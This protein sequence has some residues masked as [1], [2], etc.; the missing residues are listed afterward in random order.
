LIQKA[1]VPR[2]PTCGGYLDRNL[3]IDDYFVQTLYMAQRKEYAD[4]VSNSITGKLVMLEPGDRARSRSYTVRHL[5]GCIG[6]SQMPHREFARL[7]TEGIRHISLCENKSLLVVEDELGQAVRRSG[8]SAIQYWR[9]GHLPAKVSDVETLAREIVQRGR[10]G[11]AWL[12]RFLRSANYPDLYALCEDLFPNYQTRHLPT[13][14]TPLIG[15]E[16]DVADTLSMLKDS[17]V[18]LLTLTGAPGVGKTRLALQVAAELRQHFE[19]GVAFVQLAPIRDPERLISVIAGALGLI[20]NDDQPLN[21]RLLTFLRDRNLLLVL[22]NFE[23]VITAALHVS[24]L[25]SAA[26]RLKVLITSRESLH[27][28]G[29]YEYLVIPLGLPKP[30][31]R[32]K[33]ETLLHVPAVQLFVERARAADPLFQLSLDNAEAIATICTRL[34]G[35]PLAIELAASRSKLLTPHKILEQLND[36]LTLLVAGSRDQTARQ[37]SLQVAIEW[38]Y[39]LLSDPEKELFRRL[40]VFQGGC[41]SDAIEAVCGQSALSAQP[42]TEGQLWLLLESLGNK[43]LIQSVPQQAADDKLRCSMLE[44]IHEYAYSC[45]QASGE[46]EEIHRRHRDWCLTLAERAEKNLRGPKQLSWLR[47]LEQEIHN[48]RA[49]LAWCL[50]HPADVEPGLRLAGALYWF[51]HL[52]SYFSEGCDWLDKLLALRIDLA[53]PLS[54]RRAQAKALCIASR[55]HG[56]EANYSKAAAL[57]EAGFALSR[58]IGELD[59]LVCALTTP[60]LISRRPSTDVQRVVTLTEAILPAC[61]AAGDPFSVAQLLDNVLGQVAFTRGDYAQAA[62]LH[63]E[64]LS[65]RRSVGDI[66]GIAWSLFLLGGIARARN[67][68]ARVQELYEESRMLWQQVGNRRMYA[69]VLNELGYLALKQSRYFQASALFEENLVTHEGFGDRYRAALAQCALATVACGQSDY[70]LV[71]TYLRR[72]ATTVQQ[73]KQPLLIAGYLGVAAELA[74]T[75]GAW[76]RVTRLLG[77]AQIVLEKTNT[78]WRISERM[79]YDEMLEASRAALGE[80]AFEQAW[81]EG[82]AMLLEAAI[83]YALDE[84]SDSIQS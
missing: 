14:S 50:A 45:L 64:A 68:E 78:R 27:I 48:L 66:D 42:A 11:R 22:D 2:C 73:L 53:V 36:Q 57:S 56:F 58:E 71:R 15:R 38:S 76:D 4:F 39:A 55:L 54:T 49:A 72:L 51:W 5:A 28:Y 61:R 6:K 52:H 83:A 74:Y 35:L 59:G 33:Y 12:E 84:R 63:E 75:A 37:Q 30:E 34:D 31:A 79:R 77:V 81:R 26:P 3:R 1:D 82:Q 24:E 32:V 18:H 23:Q 69:N 19:D 21:T 8:S 43:N 7:L 67:D 9:K 17:Q 41:T 80:E 25:L 65:L 62:T 13:P 20:E 70:E 29:E 46:V 40:S 44:T 10:V 47:Y 16:Q 60:A